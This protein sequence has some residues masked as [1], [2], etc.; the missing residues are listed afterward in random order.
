MADDEN[1]TI[2]FLCCI[3][4]RLVPVYIL[5]RHRSGDRGVTGLHSDSQLGKS[6]PIIYPA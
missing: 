1:L 5:S 2:I 6:L 4:L 3:E